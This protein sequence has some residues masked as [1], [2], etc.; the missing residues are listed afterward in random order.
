MLVEC[1]LSRIFSKG[2]ASFRGGRGGLMSWESL[3]YPKTLF[4]TRPQGCALV[5][6]SMK[7]AFPF[8]YQPSSKAGNAVRALFP[9]HRCATEARLVLSTTGDVGMC[10]LSKNL[11]TIVV[12]KPD[13]TGEDLIWFLITVLK[14]IVSHSLLK[15]VL[16]D[17]QNQMRAVPLILLAWVWGTGRS[18]QNCGVRS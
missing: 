7:V 8:A 18:P 1:K 3:S 11:Q 14:P 10:G 4:L 12:L 16:P 13:P 2:P 5:K 6:E 9:A 15:L 17:L